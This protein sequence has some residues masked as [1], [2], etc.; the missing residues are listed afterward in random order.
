MWRLFKQRRWLCVLICCAVTGSSAAAWHLLAPLQRRPDV[1]SLSP[2]VNRSPIYLS[3][4]IHWPSGE[5]FRSLTIRDKES[6][7]AV[8]SLLDQ[9]ERAPLNFARE[10]C[11]GIVVPPPEAKSYSRSPY[12]VWNI[13]DGK[14]VWSDG[15]NDWM[16]GGD[17]DAVLDSLKARRIAQYLT[18]AGA[19]E[20]NEGIELRE[21]YGLELRPQVEKLAGSLNEQLAQFGTGI[22][23]DLDLQL[24][25]LPVTDDP[26]AALAKP[27][28]PVDE[29]LTTLRESLAN[30]KQDSSAPQSLLNL[31]KSCQQLWDNGPSEAAGSLAQLLREAPNVHH[32]HYLMEAVEG[33]FGLPPS[34]QPLFV[35]GNSSREELE[36]SAAEG[37][38]RLAAG[39]QKLLKWIDDNADKSEPEQLQAVLAAWHPTL[40]RLTGPDAHT[41]YSS[42]N[43]DPARALGPLLR[44]GLKLVP[45]LR[46]AQAKTLQ[47]SEQGMLEYVVASVSGECDVALVDRL[48]DGDMHQQIVA[49]QI[50][51]VAKQTDRENW[52]PTLVSFLKVPIYQSERQRVLNEA[53]FVLRDAATTALFECQGVRIL[54][55]LE[56]TCRLHFENG[57]SSQ[58]ISRYLTPE[59]P[60]AE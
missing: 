55:T 50:I 34:Y 42:I 7:A 48:L 4:D 13:G 58:L 9:S 6:I 20:R 46:L 24:D 2:D 25:P 3:I 43:R 21:I 31:L 1:S 35:C 59:W 11:A 49:C 5:R 19:K 12:P 33:A 53:G 32:T 45:P 16:L 18:A 8:V 26:R 37:R 15:E 28:K 36:A 44:H 29:L 52:Q 39:R 38:R 30:L 22:L 23:N 51:S 40:M 17:L 41:R 14:F 57:V 27:E 10:H 47:L 54:P 60:L 56:E